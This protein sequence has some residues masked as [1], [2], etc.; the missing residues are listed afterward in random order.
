LRFETG[1]R[2]V[3]L[4]RPC[5]RRVALAVEGFEIYSTD[6]SGSLN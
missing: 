5:V 6:E 2:E 4:A 3:R 1:A